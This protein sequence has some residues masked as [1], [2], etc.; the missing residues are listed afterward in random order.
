MK[1]GRKIIVLNAVTM[2]LIILIG[3][4]GYQ[5][6]NLILTKLR[7]IEIATDLNADLLEMRLSEKNLFLYGDH[8]ALMEMEARLIVTEAKING[9]EAQII[10]AI[11]KKNLAAL[12]QRLH[13]YATALH[14][15]SSGRA[16]PQKAGEELREKGQEL[17]AYSIELTEIEHKTVNEIV[18]TSYTVLFLAYGICFLLALA[19]NYGISQGILRSLR[20]IGTVARSISQGNFQRIKASRRGDEMDAVITAINSMSEELEKRE[21]QLI[22]SK[23]LASLGILTA[24][25]THELT[26][27]VNNISMIAQNFVELYEQLPRE[28]QLEMVSQIEGET[29]RIKS[30][31]TNLLN[32]SK[33]QGTK[34]AKA[35]LN[36]IIRKTMGLVQN[37][38]HVSDID[39]ELDLTEPLPPVCVDEHQIQQVLVNLI[40][41]A[42][43]AMQ[44]QG[45]LTIGTRAVAGDSKVEVTV[46]DNG[47]GIPPEY[48][49]HIFDPFFSTKGVEGTGLGLSVSYGII[50]N[51][52]GE[53]GVQSEI[54]KGTTFTVSLPSC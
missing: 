15:L 8:G 53:I 31:I 32:F 5:N 49:P 26:N 24:G 6:L 34:L 1:I 10:P 33:P 4:M 25:V 43:Q 2:L 37:M 50:K 7:F 19:V 27:P 23:K 9:S 18:A 44:P 41:N 22:Q 54:G 38:L 28:K 48:L 52:S 42:V 45:C 30:V 36:A 13:A 17:R 14:T 3:L 12:Q 21:E 39:C 40:V 29:G 46:G 11:G 47:K 35:D 20:Q 51:L 16:D